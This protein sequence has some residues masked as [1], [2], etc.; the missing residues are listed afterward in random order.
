MERTVHE[1]FTLDVLGPQPPMLLPSA[2]V[3]GR[4]RI[5]EVPDVAASQAVSDS[6]KE[7]V[8]NLLASEFSRKVSPAAQACMLDSRT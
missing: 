5:S 3:H 6:V 8:S 2:S 4:G 1:T 7:R